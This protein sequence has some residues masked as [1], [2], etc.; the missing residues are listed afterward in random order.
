M[1]NVLKTVKQFL[2]PPGKS[3]GIVKNISKWLFLA[4]LAYSSPA[5]AEEKWTFDVSSTSNSISI[6]S[7]ITWGVV[8][9]SVED[10]NQVVWWILPDNISNIEFNTNDTRSFSWRKY[11]KVAF[12][13]D[14]EQ[15]YWYVSKDLFS[16]GEQSQS[17]SEKN[18]KNI[19]TVVDKPKQELSTTPVL[20]KSQSD[21]PLLVEVSSPNLTV[22]T[23]ASSE[24]KNINETKKSCLNLVF[25]PLYNTLTWMPDYL[26]H[27]VKE[28]IRAV[29]NKVDCAQDPIAMMK[30]LRSTYNIPLDMWKSR[31]L[32]DM[33]RDFFKA[34]TYKF[35]IEAFGKTI[36]TFAPHISKD[37]PSDIVFDS[38]YSEKLNFAQ[39]IADKKI[40]DYSYL[41]PEDKQELF[42]KN[43][44]SYVKFAYYYNAIDS[45]HWINQTLSLAIQHLAYN[46]WIPYKVSNSLDSNI[47]ELADLLFVNEIW[48]DLPNKSYAEFADIVNKVWW[49]PRLR[50]IARFDT[51]TDIWI[52]RKAVNL[53]KEYSSRIEQVIE[54]NL[55]PEVKDALISKFF[56]SKEQAIDWVLQNIA[57]ES[58]WALFSSNKWATSDEMCIW[59]LN[60]NHEFIAHYKVNPFNLEQVVWAVFDEI[61][62]AFYDRAFLW[63]FAKHPNR[64]EIAKEMIMFWPWGAANRAKEFEWNIWLWSAN[65]T[66]IELHYS[67]VSESERYGLFSPLSTVMIDKYRS[68]VTARK[69]EQKRQ[70]ELLQT[71]PQQ[72]DLTT[73]SS[74]EET[75]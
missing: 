64:F 37:I 39:K 31:K 1:I 24:S 3:G 71:Q 13:A 57:R 2:A 29:K 50:Q 54:N 48:K 69:I 60:A 58:K 23:T 17:D 73:S 26:A 7:W 43:V 52:D 9:R 33:Y 61:Y 66:R 67:L 16:F 34:L 62:D 55:N 42:R 68:I 14:W 28:N 38:K 74:S 41:L 70:L 46:S 49:L 30:E 15:K 44:L 19:Q 40:K 5:L 65:S 11:I 59:L 18:I 32:N 75:M 63:K 25:W 6:K 36:Y 53:N 35:K 45:K 20:V 72:N 10:M 12:Y 56:G 47:S 4:F 21:K 8:I 22:L 27:E 51:R